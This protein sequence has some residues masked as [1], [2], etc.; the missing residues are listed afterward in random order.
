LSTDCGLRFAI[1]GEIF[2]RLEKIWK[3]AGYF[4]LGLAEQRKIGDA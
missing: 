4:A 1:L 2:F 3:D